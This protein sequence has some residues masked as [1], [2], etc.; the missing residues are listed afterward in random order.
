[1]IRLL[2]STVPHEKSATSHLALTSWRSV[3]CDNT[4]GAQDEAAKYLKEAYKRQ[5][6][7][8]GGTVAA[9]ARESAGR[10]AV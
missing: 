5:H 4:R 1:M 9:G 3:P 7:D 10:D 8:L 2:E 6:S